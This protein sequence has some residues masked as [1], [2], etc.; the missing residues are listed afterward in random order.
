MK[1]FCYAYEGMYQGLHGIED[2]TVLEVSDNIE[3]AEEEIND[4]GAE[5]SEQLIYSFGLEEEYYD[6]GTDFYEGGC[7]YAYKIK[8][9]CTLSI[10]ELDSLCSELGEE[11]FRKEYCEGDSLV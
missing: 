3:Q 9:E 5:A 7:W 11:I 2:L 1:V 4:W 6:E 8:D 10:K